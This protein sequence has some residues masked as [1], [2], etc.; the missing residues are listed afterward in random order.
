M[1]TY[2]FCQIIPLIWS[3]WLSTCKSTVIIRLEVRAFVFWQ[4]FW[5]HISCFIFKR[6][7]EIFSSTSKKNLWILLFLQ[8]LLFRY[9]QISFI[10]LPY[11]FKKNAPYQSC[12]W[13]QDIM[14][15]SYFS[16]KCGSFA[17]I[18]FSGMLV[19]LQLTYSEELLPSN[20]EP[21]PSKRW[22]L[23]SWNYQC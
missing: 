10:K 11:I 19:C 3:D 21:G 13:F 6:A 20:T 2:S 7:D 18:V 4:S 1:T 17:W 5:C 22:N 12:I 15:K 23:F 8:T 14:F 9:V 16:E